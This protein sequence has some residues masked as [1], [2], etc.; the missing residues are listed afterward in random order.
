MAC[1]GT[2][3]DHSIV[4]EIASKHCRSI[5]SRLWF[6]QWSCMDVSVGLWRKLSMEK[7]MLLNCGVGED[8]WE[9]LNCKEIQP[10]HPKGDQ[11]WVFIGQ[12]D[13]K[14][15]TPILWP[16]HA[17]WKSP[18]CWDGLAAGGEGDDWGWNG[19]MA[20]L[21]QWT[22]VWVNSGSLW[23]TGRPGV[24]R[25][26]ESQKV[27]HDWETELNCILDSFV[28]HNGYSISSK[29]FLSTVV[30]IMII[31]LKFTHSSPF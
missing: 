1:L 11:S 7:W 9:S 22:W 2:N 17:K 27:G 12:T 24:L 6:F 19:W 3:R 29:G 14:T 16:P 10:V 5:W 23:W 28:D 25:F 30:C 20:S 21:T 26:M 8:Y 18:W 15:E 13:A 31:S 4:F